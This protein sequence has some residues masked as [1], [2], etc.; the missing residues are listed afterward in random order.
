MFRYKEPLKEELSKLFDELEFKTLKKRVFGEDAAAV[1][2]AS[3]GRS[4]AKVNTN[5][6]MS[7]FGNAEEEVLTEENAEEKVFCTIKDTVHDYR[8]IDTPELISSLV[9]YLKVQ[10]EF[11]FDTETTSLDAAETDLV[12]LAFS[13]FKGEAYYVP[14][15]QNFERAK[16]IVQAFKDV[17][18]DKKITKIGQ[19]LKF[20]ILVLKGMG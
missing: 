15:P 12:G 13:Y 14:V 19:N 2:V 16:E 11:C 3:S 17:L 18:E 9:S 4:S 7:M 6:Q 20:D 5:G 10:D 8:V 1:Q